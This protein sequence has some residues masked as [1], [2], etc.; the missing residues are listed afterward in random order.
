MFNP[1]LLL[2]M[3]DFHDSVEYLRHNRN[4]SRESTAQKAGISSSSL[5]KLILQRKIP[6][7]TVFDK[8]VQFFD[9]TPTQ[10]RHLQDLL[11]PSG[12]LK[13]IDELRRRLTDQGLQAHL[14]RLNQHE[15]L[16]AYL[17]PLQTVLHGNQV[18]HR[19][20]PGL[21][22]ADH[23][24]IRWMLTPAARDRVYGWHGELLDLVRNLRTVL[25]RYRHDPRAQELFQTLRKDIAFRSAWDGTP[26]Q[27]TYDWP[28]NT[29]MRLRIPGTSKPLALNLEI[30]EY[31]A[32][33]E[34]LVVHG[35]YSTPA[36]A[37]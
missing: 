14:D 29:P 33:S 15:I 13:S 30:N 9:L 2:G 20:M 22:K 12:R 3:P 10:A 18:L 17:D 4:L 27:V 19:M 7:P 36:I 24:V 37:C 5:N 11:Q 25:A 35:L 8:L 6:G 26:M 1:P 21:D 34:V 28:R 31:G 23:N 32:C 16:G